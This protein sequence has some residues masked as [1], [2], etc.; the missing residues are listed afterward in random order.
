MLVG[1][2]S[3]P[4]LSNYFISFNFIFQNLV[5]SYMED[6]RFVAVDYHLVH[7]RIASSVAERLVGQ[8]TWEEREVFYNGLQVIMSTSKF[9]SLCSILSFGHSRNQCNLDMHF[10]FFVGNPSF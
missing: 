6:A 7:S 10:F 1:Y 5:R 8:L 2:F 3:L 4:C 9:F